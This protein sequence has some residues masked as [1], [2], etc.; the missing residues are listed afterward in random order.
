MFFTAEHTLW[1]LLQSEICQYHHLDMHTTYSVVKDYYYIT[2]SGVPAFTW[3]NLNS[4][5][6][7]DTQRGDVQYYLKTAS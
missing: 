5:T 4:C 7:G 3:T 2:P 1:Q 6:V